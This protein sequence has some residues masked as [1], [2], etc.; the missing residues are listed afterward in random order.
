MEG[1]DTW[2]SLEHWFK[3]A[4]QYLIVPATEVSS[5][6]GFSAVGLTWERCLCGL[7]LADDLSL[8]PTR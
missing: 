2:R 3:L 8:Q 1:I 4:K 7:M 5:E 6:R